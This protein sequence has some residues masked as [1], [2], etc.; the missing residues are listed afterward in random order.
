MGQICRWGILGAAGIARK[1][2]RS[3]L[4]AG[5]A[6]VG[7]VASRDPARAQAFI[8]DCQGECPF[9]EAPRACTYDD[10]IAADDI[11]AV[12]IPLPTGLRKPWV[13]AAATFFGT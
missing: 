11:D 8:D 12:Y 10:M 1:N 13:I 9:S 7:A 2:W 4:N 5:N 6:V 3:I